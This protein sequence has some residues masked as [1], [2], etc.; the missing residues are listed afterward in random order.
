MA[1]MQGN[2]GEESVA[3]CTAESLQTAERIGRHPRGGLDF[4]RDDGTVVS[5][6]HQ[7]YLLP[8][9]GS[10]VTDARDPVEP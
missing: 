4:E 6:D 1:G 2:A 8:A 5:F 9:V 3:G 10:P 7:V